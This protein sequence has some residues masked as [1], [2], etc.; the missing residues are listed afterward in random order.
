VAVQLSTPYRQNP[1]DALYPILM[2]LRV[3]A[4]SDD[5]IDLLNS[6]WGEGGDDA[7][8]DHQHLRAKNCD[9]DAVNDRRLSQLAGEPVTFNCVDTVNVEHPDR[10]AAVYAKLQTLARG[11]IQVKPGAEVVL[12]RSVGELKTGAR[13]RVTEAGTA[14]V[15]CSFSGHTGDV[16]VRGALFEVKDAREEV[17]GTRFQVPL[18]LAWAMTITRAQGMTLPAVAIDFGC[19]TWAPEGMVYSGC[20]RSVSFSSL[21]VRGLTRGHVKASAHGLRYYQELE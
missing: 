14:S 9:V 17:L 10:Q 16:E 7:W 4:P 6:T 20:S 1:D 2:R 21:R 19:T 8:P 11:V 15:H 13:G 5:D 3:G 12:T 18:L